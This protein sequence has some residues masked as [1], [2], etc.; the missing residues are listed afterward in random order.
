M[1]KN[2]R[3]RLL[4]DVETSSAGNAASQGGSVFSSSSNIS[5]CA[6]G[7]SMLSL[8]YVLYISG[9]L[10]GMLLLVFSGVLSSL[11]AKAIYD[12]G[13][14]VNKSSYAGITRSILGGHAGVVAEIM[15]ALSLLFAAITYIVG[16]ADLLPRVFTFTKVISRTGRIT[17]LLFIEFWATLVS[18]L[19]VFGPASALVCIGCYI[20]CGAM[21]FETF[22]LFSVSLSPSLSTRSILSFSN[23]TS[24]HPRGF[25]YSLSITAFVFA[26]HFIYTDTIHE[27][28][29]PTPD[30]AW[31]LNKLTFA[32]LLGCYIPFSISGYLAGSIHGHIGTNVLKNLGRGS[33]TVF[34][35][36]LSITA[37]LIITYPLL[38]IP[39]RR[40]GENL[41]NRYQWRSSIWQRRYMVNGFLA[42]SI[43][44]I[45][46]LLTDLGDANAV[47]GG[48]I[49]TV[50][51]FFPG[52][53][54]LKL[55]QNGQE[56]DVKKM[57]FNIT[58]GSA[59]VLV[60]VTTSILGVFGQALFPEF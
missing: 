7:A 15:L 45:S 33:L 3:T 18:D 32:I 30:R 22:E 8:P 20:L 11:A 44:L 16:L 41:L 34:I 47:A 12:A 29:D 37:L 28:K 48:C 31:K 17:L 26:Y 5:A 43:G 4:P 23:L 54:L 58:L 14:I 10:W 13:R 49:V 39:L 60:S 6:F 9:P 40:R 57:V 55:N 59:L 21:I 2:E 51:Y 36:R 53:F 35:A 24:F 46:I 1:E 27:L 38:V 19:S 25:L 56:R 52:L 50:M 42:F